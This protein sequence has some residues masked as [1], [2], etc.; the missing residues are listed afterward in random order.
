MSAQ[1]I[2]I[3]GPRASGKSAFAGEVH[4]ALPGSILL[5]VDEP[6]HRI[7]DENRDQW[8]GKEIE[9]Y[10][11]VLRRQLS[12]ARG[13]ACAGGCVI[14]DGTV[15]PDQLEP[16]R[17]SPASDV[18]VIV[19]LPTLEECLANEHR[20]TRTVPVREEKVTATWRQMQEWRH[21]DQD[22]VHILEVPQEDRG[23]W[24][25]ALLLRMDGKL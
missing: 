6:F 23:D 12:L 11:S 1:V 14:V 24:L 9:L 13:A 21:V 3:T 16:L 25:A 8:T 5:H 20:S 22:F 15:L 19:L 2:V 7:L 17:A 10:D 18:T 4:A